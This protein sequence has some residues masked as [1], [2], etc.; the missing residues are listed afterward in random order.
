MRRY[1][2]MELAK[3]KLPDGK[4]FI[5]E[6]ALLARRAPQIAVSWDRPPPGGVPIA[7]ADETY[8]MGLQVNMELGIPYVQHG[9]D[10]VGFKSGFFFLPE[11]GVGGVILGNSDA[12]L[13]RVFLR[14]TLELLFDGNAEA[15]EDLM[16]S[17]ARRRSWV[18]EERVHL[19]LPADP[20][21]VA[22][23][24]KRYTNPTLGDIVV[25]TDAK[26]TVFD[27]GEWKSTVA[28][29]KNDDETTTLV[30]I[31]P[32]VGRIDFVVSDQAGV[33]RLLL[34]DPQHEHVFEEAGPSKAR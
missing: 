3:G 18:A 15:A 34:R 30:P 20:T 2:Q 1:H 19:V 26:G 32:G 28:S 22:K 12:T 25:R 31:D 8:G 6:E 21:V 17:A 9:G 14:R 27:F 33:R 4:R 24:A 10:V 16:L 23:L 7:G 11:H 13:R 29:R 5:S